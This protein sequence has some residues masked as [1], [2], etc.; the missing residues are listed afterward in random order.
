M[1]F[2]LDCSIAMAWCFEDEATEFT[3]SLLEELVGGSIKVPSIWFLEVANVLAIS[4]RRG[5]SNQ[6]KISQFL[7]LL[8]SLPITV[9]TKTEE[10]AF[11]DILTLARTHKLT[12]YDAAYLE[13]ALREG[14]P[15]ATL[16]EGLKRVASNVGVTT[17]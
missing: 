13:L 8:V 5:R 6:A 3:D 16:D 12:S 4:E 11:T 17:L 2:V 9:D 15:L 1:N 10:K 14:L 7:G